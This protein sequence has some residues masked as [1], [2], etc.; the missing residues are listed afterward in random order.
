MSKLSLEKHT[1]RDGQFNEHPTVEGENFLRPPSTG[2]VDH[3]VNNVTPDVSK[4]TE[5]PE[6]A[7]KDGTD[8]LLPSSKLDDQPIDVAANEEISAVEIQQN[9]AESNSTEKDG[10][11]GTDSSF[12]KE[13]ETTGKNGDK[14]STTSE[15]SQVPLHGD[16]DDVTDHSIPSVAE[17]SE[18]ASLAQVKDSQIECDEHLE[19]ESERLPAT[20]VST[21]EINDS[22]P[23]ATHNVRDKDEDIIEAE[24]SENEPSLSDLSQKNSKQENT[25]EVEEATVDAVDRQ[26]ESLEV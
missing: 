2:E 12:T 8:A 18:E 4:V 23:E 13:E 20:E 19:E 22:I 10:D 25:I 9:G 14:I 16:E 24:L 21:G 15:D 11:N 17:K 26:K 5:E 1:L 7:V 6:Q 3:E